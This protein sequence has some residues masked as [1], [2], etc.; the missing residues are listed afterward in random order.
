MKKILIVAG[1]VL[2]FV[3]SG[4]AAVSL[5][6]ASERQAEA[7]AATAGT[8]RAEIETIVRDYLLANPEILLEMQ[9]AL[10]QKMRQQQEAASR[11]AIAEASDLIFNSEYDGVVGN[12]DG[13][14]T[15]VEF[16][17]YN[18][19]YCK[20]ALADMEAL[21]QSDPNLR[22]VLKEFP[23]LGPESHEAHVVS[24]AFRE[25]MPEKYGDFHRRL[26]GGGGR[27]DGES[28]MKIALDLGADESQLRERMRDPEIEAAFRKTYELADQL[29]I[30]GTPSYVIGQEVVF[31]ALG[32]DHLSEKIES[33]RQ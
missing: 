16:F 4:L 21:V 15:V 12:P 22:F 25:L 5:T 7:P 20:R 1:A 17:D 27:A 24:M 8:G 33:A 11:Q 14:V 18:C 29:Q 28:A 19:G 31:G 13:D 30:T 10:E 6:T 23:I 3:A 32:R 2:A 9:T 26:L